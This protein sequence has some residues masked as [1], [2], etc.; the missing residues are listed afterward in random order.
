MP[1]PDAAPTL[2]LGPQ[3]DGDFD[4]LFAEVEAGFQQPQTDEAGTHQPEHVPVD[5]A[6]TLGRV[7]IAN[8][9]GDAPIPGTKLE[10]GVRPEK[11]PWGWPV[12]KRLSPGHHPHSHNIDA[13]RPKVEAAIDERE[14]GRKYGDHEAAIIQTVAAIKSLNIKEYTNSY[15]PAG[16]VPYEASNDHT[17]YRR[18]GAGSVR[19]RRPLARML[20]AV[21]MIRTPEA[22]VGD[23]RKI[24]LRE[25]G[26]IQGFES[27]MQAVLAADESGQLQEALGSGHPQLV[28][29]TLGELSAHMVI[30]E[31]NPLHARW[32]DPMKPEN[33]QKFRRYLI[34]SMNNEVHD[35]SPLA[36]KFH[37]TASGIMGSMRPRAV[38]DYLGIS[39]EHWDDQRYGYPDEEEGQHKVPKAVVDQINFLMK[40]DSREIGGEVPDGEG[41]MRPRTALDALIEAGAAQPWT[42]VLHGPAY[43]TPMERVEDPEAVAARDELEL[44]DHEY[45]QTRGFS[46]HYGTVLS[47]IEQR[48]AGLIDLDDPAYAEE[49]ES[50]KERKA[51]IREQF[52]RRGIPIPG[53]NNGN[54]RH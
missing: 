51:S 47:E 52:R 31:S 7:A 54:G 1:N 17:A 53:E 4:T 32:S 12:V 9:S 40:L 10:N 16:K 41:G 44:Q 20:S 29:H 39:Y 26:L 28:R 5:I 15:K 8:E 22:Q 6:H 23:E 18:S 34:E 2:P 25:I 11:V 48:L 45:R 21:G 14:R 24:A 19:S 50:L 43:K 13:V 37:I 36:A 42:Q 49:I 46:L 27:S 30:P 3:E 35:E 38:A 33:V